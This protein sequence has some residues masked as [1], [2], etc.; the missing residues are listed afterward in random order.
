MSWPKRLKKQLSLFSM[1]CRARV[2]PRPSA[3]SSRM[4][5]GRRVMPTPSSFTSGALSYTRQERPRCWRA[6]AS[7]SP[8]MPPPTIAMSMQPEPSPEPASAVEPGRDEAPAVVE[9]QVRPVILERG[10]P[11]R[12]VV[13]LLGQVPLDLVEG[14]LPAFQIAG[15][16]LAHEKVVE[17]GVVHV[18]PVAR[19][20]RVVLPEEEAVGL[21]ERR[22]RSEYHR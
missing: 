12:H 7:V 4:A 18:A 5:C 19:L 15:A 13:L 14:I 22:Q 6:S 21:E 2:S 9:A 10:V 11:H 17:R 8:P 20:A 16:A 1:P 3:L